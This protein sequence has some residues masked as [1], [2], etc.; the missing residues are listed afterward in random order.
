MKNILRLMLSSLIAIATIGC[1]Y[2][3]PDVENNYWAAPQIKELTERGVIVGY[4]DGTFKPDENVTRAEFASMAIKALGQEKINVAQP[5]NF[6][7]ITTEYW[8]YNSIQKALYFD[9]ISCPP[10]GTAFRPDDSVS[11]AESISMAVNALT[12]EQI[13]GIKAVE[14]L[15]KRYS[16][17]EITPEW[18]L[19]PAGKAE[20]LNMIVIMPSNDKAK[21]DAERPATRAEVAAILSKMIAEARLNPNA[22][23]AEV[24]RKKTGEGYII[25][26]A[27][28]QGSVGTIPAG[29]IVPVELSKAINSQTSKSGDI[30]VATAPQNYVTKENFILIY[31]GANLKGQ[32]LDVRKGTWFVRNGMLILDNALVVTNNDQTAQFSAVGEVTKHRNWFMKIVRKTLKGE[33]LEVIPQGTVYI[34]L[35]KPIKI[36]LTNGWI[37]EQD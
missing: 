24:M 37:I 20:I 2:A 7:D 32:L 33:K 35:L 26:D 29:T 18:F 4:P 30:Y 10:A 8:A 5:V 1:A 16:D 14:V 12:T 23:L 34:K 13:T 36:N 19:I 21:L 22:K 25:E 31:Q 9:L 3:F 6:T 17:V 11:R 27:R 15:K 28:V